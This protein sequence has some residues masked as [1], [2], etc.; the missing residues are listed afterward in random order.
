MQGSATLMGLP[1]CSVPPTKFTNPAWSVELMSP[2]KP[3]VV[4]A[5]KVAA[6]VAD[7]RLLGCQHDDDDAHL[8]MV[9]QTLSERSARTTLMI[10]NVPVLYT[11]EMLLA[12]WPNN[13]T[14]DFLYLPFSCSM[15]RNLSYAFVNFASE[16][17]ALAFAA[18]WQKKR[19]AHYTSRKPL[20]ISFADVQGRDGNLWELKKK[21][22]KRI[23]VNQC[24]PLI[25]ENGKRVTL[26]EALQ[27]LEMRTMAMPFVGQVFS[28]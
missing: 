9:I 24:Q 19:L 27:D 18:K 6:P 8:D 4:P 20:N 28:L 13:A 1:A 3:T 11:R 7:E 22:V 26:A 17:M 25:F 10:R 23:K 21:R 2:T 15:Q 5:A 14:Y 12:E 16:E